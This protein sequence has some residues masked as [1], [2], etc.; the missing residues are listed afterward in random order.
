M[1]FVG[2]P[3]GTVGDLEGDGLAAA[4]AAMASWDDGRLAERYLFGMCG[5]FALALHAITGW[6]TV[7]VFDGPGGAWTDKPRHVG[8]VSPD[9]YFAD[10]RGVGMSR[11]SFLEGYG[12][13]DGSETEVRPFLPVDV[14]RT[15]GSRSDA[16]RELAFEHVTRLLPEVADRPSPGR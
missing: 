5:P 9:G 14:A 10:A 4:A 15:F 1:T 7:G 13:A 12:R 6:D 3:G 8:C 11:E 2:Y 16:D